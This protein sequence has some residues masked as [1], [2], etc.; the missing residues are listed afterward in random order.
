[1][2]QSYTTIVLLFLPLYLL[3]SSFTTTCYVTTAFSVN[4][5]KVTTKIH[6]MMKH[7]GVSSKSTSLHYLSM[8][9]SSS[10]EQEGEETNNSNKEKI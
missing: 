2:K 5:N 7:V 10:S 3:V 9:S 6:S 4:N 8:S 1:M